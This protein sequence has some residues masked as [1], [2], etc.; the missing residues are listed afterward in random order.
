MEK[1]HCQAIVLHVPFDIAFACH[2]VRMHSKKR[3]DKQFSFIGKFC[4]LSVFQ[5]G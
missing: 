1:L 5:F 3:L 4:E 2:N